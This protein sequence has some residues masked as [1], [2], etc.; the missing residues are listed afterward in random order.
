MTAGG[1]STTCGEENKSSANKLD[2]L[3]RLDYYG[4]LSA[5]L[6]WRR[7]PCHRPIRVV[8]GGWGAPTAALLQDDDV[9]VDYK[10]FWIACKDAEEAN[11]LLAI[12]NSDTLYEMVTPL[13]SKGQFGARDL[14]KHLWKLPIPEFDPEDSLHTAVSKAG[15]AASVGAADQL[16]QLHEERDRVTVTIARRELRKWLRTSPEGQAVEDAVS[17]LLS[18]QIMI[19]C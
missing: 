10:L 7:N 17:T 11:Y 19:E 3:E 2:L 5:Q 9:I 6:D 1:S 8:Y 18:Q 16:A 14:Q 15:E 13:M 12:I 4:N